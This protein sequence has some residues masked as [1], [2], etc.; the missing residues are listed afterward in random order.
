MNFEETTHLGVKT[1]WIISDPTV[2]ENLNVDI[3]YPNICINKN[4]D[5]VLRFNYPYP[6]SRYMSYILY[7]MKFFCFLP[8]YLEK[9]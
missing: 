6:N 8:L 5:L 2:F 4:I 7:I 3:R 1:V 9:Y